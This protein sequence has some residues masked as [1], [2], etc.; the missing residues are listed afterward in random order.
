[1]ALVTGAANGL[2]RA[3]S[4][5]LAREGMAVGAVDRDEEA[6][7]DLGADL[8]RILAVEPLLDVPTLGD[9]LQSAGGGGAAAGGLAGAL[10][11]HCQSGD[12]AKRG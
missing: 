11:R 5:A 10:L 4:V 7:G 12:S 1:M 8:D 6:L 2:G 9:V 3:L